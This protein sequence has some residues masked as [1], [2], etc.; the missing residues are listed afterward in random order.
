MGLG[1]GERVEKEAE[2]ENMEGRE[3]GMKG[4]RRKGKLKV[5][6]ER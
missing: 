4:K 6:E 3:G 1:G 2:G 5:R